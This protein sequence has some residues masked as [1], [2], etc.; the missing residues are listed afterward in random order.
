MPDYKQGKIY[1]IRCKTDDTL[2][3]VGCTTQSLCE[4]MAKHKYDS[5]KRPNICF[6]QHV[7]DWDNWYIELFENFPCNGKEELNKKEGQVI[8]EIGTINK[9]IAGRTNKE[10]YKDNKEKVIKRIK[11]NDDN[12]KHKSLEKM[13]EYANKNKDTIQEN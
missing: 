13:K 6:Y 3:Y 4:R 12:N 11:E 8:R 2:I 5:M 1:T 10:W 7:D 9:Q